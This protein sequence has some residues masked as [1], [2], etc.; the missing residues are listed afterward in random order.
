M[1]ELA[2]SLWSPICLQPPGP[3]RST[4]SAHLPLTDARAAPVMPRR[5]CLF[6]SLR[7]NLRDFLTIPADLS[8]SWCP[9]PVPSLAQG[10]LC[11]ARLEGAP[12]PAVCCQPLLVLVP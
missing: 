10:W 2:N 9:G 3:F 5:F 12:G 7:L 6:H 11:L 4:A 1:A 8:S